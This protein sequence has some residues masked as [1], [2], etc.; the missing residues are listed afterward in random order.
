MNNH[1]STP[2]NEV[3]RAGK[4]II[5]YFL[6]RK[7]GNADSQGFLFGVTMEEGTKIPQ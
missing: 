1:F 7:G 6:L 2:M 5:H 3:N 4:M